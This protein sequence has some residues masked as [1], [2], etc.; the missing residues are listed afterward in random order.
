MIRLLLAIVMLLALPQAAHAEWSKASSDHFI[1]YADQSEN[2]LREFTERLE[3]Y[4]SAL[5]ANFA[6]KRGIPS[7][8][9]RVTIF[10][11]ENLYEVRKLSGNVNSAVAGFYIPRATGAV[12]YIPKVKIRSIEQDFSE[13]VLLH[14]YTH[15]YMFLA[16]QRAYPLW[17]TEGFAEYYATAKF[18]RD[19]TVGLG[20]PAKHRE[21]EIRYAKKVPFKLMLDTKAYVESKKNSSVYDRFYGQ[22]WALYHYLQFSPNRQGQLAKYF[23]ELIT[24]KGELESAKAAFGDLKKLEREVDRYLRSGRMSYAKVPADKLKIGDIDIRKLNDGEAAIMPVVMIS[25][26]GVDKKQAEEVL[27]DARKVAARYPGNATVLNALSE[28]EFDAGNDALAIAAADK[29]IALDGSQMNAYVQKANSY[30]RLAEK[31]KDEEGDA[32]PETYLLAAREVALAANK[33]ENNYPVPLIQ[34]FQTYKETGTTPPAAA[35]T[36]LEWALE[37]APFDSALRLQVA[38]Q[39]LEEKRYPDAVYTLLP[40]AYSA[41]GDDKQIKKANQ[42]LDVATSKG[43]VPMPPEEDEDDEKEEKEADT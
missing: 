25:K 40:L 5:K 18:E 13:T 19:G 4:H 33:V 2:D 17:F 29:A 42:Y 8:S 34:Y 3:K 16:A 37:L 32:N 35:V 9:N 23:E 14:E 43:E 1:V 12:A 6:S 21:N 11:V 10:V 30:L 20:Y 41:H 15:H 26:R 22:S 28:A 36:G 24:G 39:Q 38:R 7:P 27:Q 31:A